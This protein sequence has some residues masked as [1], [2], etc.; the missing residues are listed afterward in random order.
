MP[1]TQASPRKAEH[2]WPAF[3]AIAVM[4]LLDIYSPPTF[5]PKIA[6]IVTVGVLLIPL[7]VLNPHR[8]TRETRW[9]RWLSIGLA[10]VLA[11]ANQVDVVWIIHGLIS[12]GTGGI[13]VLWGALQVW[14][15]SVVT[16]ALIYWELDRGGP[17]ARGTLTRVQ[18]QLADFKFP[19]DEDESSVAEVTKRSST[20]SDWRPGFV[21]YLYMSST[22]MMA[23]SPTDVMPLSS[24]A[25][26]FMMLQSM[27]GFVL[28]ALVIARSVNILA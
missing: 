27:T 23:F 26:L 1:R 10:L 2:R 17:V 3:A 15:A 11:I 22:N 8:L 20:R 16:F 19:Q 13:T 28:L 25:K 5:I 12:G 7:I 6:L 24:R 21:D 9:S 4:L 18:L 14:V